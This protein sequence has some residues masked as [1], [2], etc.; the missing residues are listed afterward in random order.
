MVGL[1]WAHVRGMWT[2]SGVNYQLHSTDLKFNPSYATLL[3]WNRTSWASPITCYPIIL[4]TPH[5]SLLHS[6]I[7]L[8]N[9]YLAPEQFMLFIYRQ[10]SL[11]CLFI[12]RAVHEAKIVWCSS[13]GWAQLN[14]FR[15][16]LANLNIR[17]IFNSFCSHR[18]QH[19]SGE[20]DLSICLII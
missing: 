5:H 18:M 10:S 8:H 7:F 16:Q 19:G 15:L 20:L 14:Q 2:T 11:C 9:V 17:L 4:P 3:L 12:A 6:C 13:S 1:I